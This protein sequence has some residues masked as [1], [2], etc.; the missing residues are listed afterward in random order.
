MSVPFS[1]GATSALK[2]RL[3]PFDNLY[4]W[5]DDRFQVL[6]YLPDGSW[7]PSEPNINVAEAFFVNLNQPTN[8]LVSTN[9]P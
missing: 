6:T 3:G 8:W 5:R 1:G 2:L 7:F 4:V 9:A